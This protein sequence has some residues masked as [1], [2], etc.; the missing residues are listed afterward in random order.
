MKGVERDWG[1]PVRA[2][3][4]G[5]DA[6]HTKTAGH[7]GKVRKGRDGNGPCIERNSKEPRGEKVITQ[8]P[9]DG[10]RK[11]LP[12][13]FLLCSA[14]GVDRSWGMLAASTCSSGSL[15]TISVYTG[16]CVMASRLTSSSNTSTGLPAGKANCKQGEGGRDGGRDGGREAVGSLHGVN[17]R[18]KLV[19]HLTVPYLKPCCRQLQLGVSM[20]TSPRQERDL[21]CWR[22]RQQQMGREGGGLGEGSPCHGAS[23]GVFYSC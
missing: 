15:S 8:A 10:Q 7:W 14:T 19:Q 4:K 2:G 21:H 13:T 12:R 20:L 23:Y 18:R 16:S 3:A 11:E 1:R 22:I 6:N 5:S 17:R 9:S